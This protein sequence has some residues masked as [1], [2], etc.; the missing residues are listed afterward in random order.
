MTKT[1]KTT[2]FAGPT[3]QRDTL[4]G[5][6]LPSQSTDGPTRLGNWLQ[7]FSGIQFFP[8]DPHPD[9]IL[10]ED[11]AHSLSNQCRYAGHTNTFYSVAEHCYRM[12]FIVPKKD[13]L[14]ALLHDAS[15]AYLVDLPRPLKHYSKLGEIYIMLENRVMRVVAE[16][17]DLPTPC[18]ASVHRADNIMLSTEQRDLMKISPKPWVET[19]K[20]LKGVIFPINPC[21]AELMF[22]ERFAELEQTGTNV[23]RH[24]RV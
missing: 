18:P 12:S 23:R 24:T 21:A 1:T 14:W 8:L 22:L 11:I 3:S 2:A 17:F 5:G 10:I 16:R 13:A 4:G 6:L 15:E 20:P 19:E 7:T 9:E